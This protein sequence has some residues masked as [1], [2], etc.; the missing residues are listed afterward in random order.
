MKATRRGRLDVSAQGGIFCNLRI[1]PAWRWRPGQENA[2]CSQE[3]PATRVP[4]TCL[5]TLSETKQVYPASATDLPLVW[6]SALKSKLDY[7]A[8]RPRQRYAPYTRVRTC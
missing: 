3:D 4:A 5:W 8:A 2:A 1:W 6:Q 7:L